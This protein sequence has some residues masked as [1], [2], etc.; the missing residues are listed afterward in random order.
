MSLIAKKTI[1]YI[2]SRKRIEGTDSDFLYQVDFSREDYDSVVIL[3]ANIPKSYYLIESGHNTFTL[4]EGII[5]VTI[6]VPAGNYTRSSLR[7][8][9]EALL[10]Q[11]SPNGWA[12]SVSVPASTDAETGKYTFSVSGNGGIQ[13]SFTFTTY[14]FEQLGFN[15]NSVNNFVS[16]SLVSSN[17]IKLQIED[18]LFIHSDICTNGKDNILQEIYATDTQD[19]GNIVFVNP[20]IEAYSKT[21]SSKHNNVYRF[22]IS[23]ENDVELDM[24]GLNVVFTLMAYK[25]ESLYRGLRQYLK[26]KLLEN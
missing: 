12:Y 14:L 3:Q 6:A 4:T 8:T 13:P 17:V 15:E 16:D 7:G 25:K 26:L 10:T 1:F 21:I 22:Y 20:N 2:G 19:Y 24:N 5:A 11:N 23:D 9:I 18:A